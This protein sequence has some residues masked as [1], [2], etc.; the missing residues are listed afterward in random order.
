M[1]Y[2]VLRIDKLKTWGDVGGCGSHN[3]RQRPTPNADNSRENR[4][5]VGAPDADYVEVVRAKIGDQTIRK[6]AV[7]AVELVLSA[8]PEYF[9]PDAPEKGGTWD[10]ASLEPWV[11]ANMAWLDQK[12][13][14]RVVS[15]ILHLDELTPHIQAVLVPLDDAGKLNARAMFGGSRHTLSALQTDYAKSVEHLGI[16]RGIEGSKAVHVPPREYYD[17][18]NAAFER[19]PELP[20]RPSLRTEPEKPALLASKAEKAAYKADHAAW[21]AE[22]AAYKDK[23]NEFNAALA[24][25]QQAAVGV[26]RKHEA[27]AAEAAALRKQVDQLKRSNGKLSKQVDKLQGLLDEALDIAGLFTPSEVAKAEERRRQQDA[28]R[29]RQAEIARQQAAEAAQRAE[30]EQE[31]ARRVTELPKLLKAAGAALTFAAKATA[32]LK[33]AGN[34]P[35]KVD[36]RAIEAATAHEAMRENGQLPEKVIEALTRHSPGRADPATHEEI[37]RAVERHAPA[38]LA[39]YEQTESNRPLSSGPRP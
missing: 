13:G 18:A 29:R 34:D 36:W 21:E 22:R 24:K 33:A 11:E 12:Y 9:R 6:N 7:L 32:A 8:S 16:Q 38:L 5:L 30:I 35:A 23:A 37:K 14:D 17:R 2:T 27:Q 31:K 25:R 28:E 20:P 19:L 3:L 1:P 26:A 4:M 15:A 39:E 10:V